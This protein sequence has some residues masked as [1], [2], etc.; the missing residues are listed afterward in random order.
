MPRPNKSPVR[1][2]TWA[3]ADQLRID[4]GGTVETHDTGLSLDELRSRYAAPDGGPDAAGFE[5]FCADLFRIT[6]TPQQRDGA[7]ACATNSRVL[8][9]GGNS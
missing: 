9:V 5:R 1:Q 8:I 4:V 7:A 6:L 2:A 3:L